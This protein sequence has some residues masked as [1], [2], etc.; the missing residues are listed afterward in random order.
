LVVGALVVVISEVGKAR[1]RVADNLAVD[2]RTAT[3]RI[4]FLP[5]CILAVTAED[6]GKT[7]DTSLGDE[8]SQDPFI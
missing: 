3:G 8:G 5:A 2:P 7:T 4:W 6:P 1:V